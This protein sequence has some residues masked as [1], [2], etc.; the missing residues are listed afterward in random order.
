[1]RYEYAR[2]GEW[3]QPVCRGYKL[4]CCDCGRV[5][6]LDFRVHRGRVQFRGRRDNRSTAM[7]R[8]WA[9]RRQDAKDAAKAAR[10]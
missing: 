2:E 5:D 3:E 8:R 6:R 9:Q 1:M 7:V 4:I 10:K